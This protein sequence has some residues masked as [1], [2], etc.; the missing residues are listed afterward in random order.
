M[1]KK[2]GCVDLVVSMAAEMGNETNLSEKACLGQ[3]I[4][5][6]LDFKYDAVVMNVGGKIML[7]DGGEREL[8]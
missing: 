8:L 2:A 6:F 7:L 3:P 5:A 1:A 4:H